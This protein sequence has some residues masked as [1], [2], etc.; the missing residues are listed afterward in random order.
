MNAPYRDLGEVADR[1]AMEKG[2][3][4]NED[5][6]RFLDFVAQDADAG[7]IQTSDEFGDALMDRMFNQPKIV[8]PALRMRKFDD[9]LRFPP[10]Q[11]TI[12]FGANGSGKSLITTQVALDMAMQ[13]EYPFIIS[14]EMAPISTLH[15]MVKQ[16]AGTD[17]PSREWAQAFIRWSQARVWIYNKR[18]IKSV[19]KLLN[20]C[21]FAA[22][23]LGVKQIFIDSLM[24]CVKGTDDHDGQKQFVEK[25]TNLAAAAGVHVHIVH[26]IRKPENDDT[27]PNKYDAR[28]AGEIIDMVDAAVAVWRNKKKERARQAG[29][30]LDDKG[31]DVVLAIEKNRHIEF[32]ARVGVN[33]I[34][35][36]QAYTDVAHPIKYPELEDWL[37]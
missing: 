8:G 33:Y 36:A 16:S 24:K 2:I 22:R 3:L 1:I 29:Q 10:G 21:L 25:C 37:E 6:E 31:F 7:R 28:G 13:D 15:R 19:D 27:I 9:K 17:R 32:E 23:R 11:V 30:P 20:L 34:P 5:D 12:W 35:G 4:L 26:H 18:E 14:L